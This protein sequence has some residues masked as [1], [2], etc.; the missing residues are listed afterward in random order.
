MRRSDVRTLKKDQSWLV[1]TFSA[2]KHHFLVFVEFSAAGS[3]I[4]PPHAYI[5]AS[6]NLRRYLSRRKVSAIPVSVFRKEFGARDAW[7]ELL[8]D[9][10]A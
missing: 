1:G 3:P 9:R 8:A 7:Q 2:R 5:V 10:A 4:A 6:E